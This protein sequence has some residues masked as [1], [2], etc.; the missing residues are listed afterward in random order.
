MPCLAK[1]I[2]PSALPMLSFWSKICAFVEQDTSNWPLIDPLPSYGRGRELPGGRYMSLIHGNGLQDVF[3]TGSC[4]AYLPLCHSLF[5]TCNIHTG[6]IHVMCNVHA[7]HFSFISQLKYH[8][9]FFLF[10]I[11]A[12]LVT[13]AGE[14][15]TIDGQ[16]SVW[17][18]MWRQRTLPFTRPHLLELISSTD[19]TI[20]NVVFQDSPFWTIHPVY[21]RRAKQI[22]FLLCTLLLMT[23]ETKEGKTFLEAKLVAAYLASA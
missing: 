17:W 10:K 8:A 7:Q 4:S 18:D 21:C 3:I 13:C 12:F 22:T 20:S 11:G 6:I 16:G 9:A 15:G 14:N 19:V 2:L 1:K 23:Y 5:K